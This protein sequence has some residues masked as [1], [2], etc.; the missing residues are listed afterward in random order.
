MPVSQPIMVNK[1]MDYDDWPLLMVGEFRVVL[2]R[3]NGLIIKQYLHS[4]YY[5]LDTVLIAL[6]VLHFSIPL[7]V[8]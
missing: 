2:G 5:I 1:G 7:K 3:E 6:Y 4:T 8:F